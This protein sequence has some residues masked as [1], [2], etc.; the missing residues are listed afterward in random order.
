M[1]VTPT[2]LSTTAAAIDGRES[3]VVWLGEIASDVTG[4]V[5]NAVTGRQTATLRNGQRVVCGEKLCQG[6]DSP[7]ADGPCGCLEVGR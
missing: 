7:I 5:T 1:T 4:Y 2:H 3:Y 6:C